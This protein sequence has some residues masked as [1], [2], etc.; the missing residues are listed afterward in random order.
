[1]VRVLVF[2][3]H[4]VQKQADGIDA[5]LHSK[6]LDFACFAVVEIT[7]HRLKRYVPREVRNDTCS[8]SIEER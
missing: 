6:C 4:I 1:M 5:D 7:L 2:L 3:F 8:S